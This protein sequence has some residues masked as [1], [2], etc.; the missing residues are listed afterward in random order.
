MMRFTIQQYAEARKS[1][2][3]AMDQIEPDGKP[4]SVCGDND[5]MAYEC[6]HNPLVA[7]FMCQQIAENS[8]KLHETLHQLA[9]FNF[10]MGIQLGP[11]RVIV[12][13]VK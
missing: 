2:L 10:H 9:G 5:H 8:E 7:M 3:D 13:E 1:L 6:G 11:K 12:P 4:C